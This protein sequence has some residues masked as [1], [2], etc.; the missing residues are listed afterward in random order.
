MYNIYIYYTHTHMHIYDFTPCIFHVM[1][2][3]RFSPL[4]YDL[5][6]RKLHIHMSL[7]EHNLCKCRKLIYFQT[8]Y[9]NLKFLCPHRNPDVLHVIHTLV[10]LILPAFSSASS[11]RAHLIS[12]CLLVYLSVLHRNITSAAYNLLISLLIEFSDP[13]VKID[14]YNVFM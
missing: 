10:S 8:F 6:I 11:I 1:S 2:L 14:K 9:S 7:Q 13:F 5:N 3:I 12:Y 4:N